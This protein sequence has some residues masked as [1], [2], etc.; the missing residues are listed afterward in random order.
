MVILS[1]IQ[2]RNIGKYSLDNI[3]DEFLNNTPEPEFKNQ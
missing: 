1:T 2:Y 3:L